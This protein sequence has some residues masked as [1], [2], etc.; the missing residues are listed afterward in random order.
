MTF[1]PAI[2][3]NRIKAE[4]T[5]FIVY[6]DLDWLGVVF[7]GDTLY[8]Y[9]G[10]V[11][12]KRKLLG[13]MTDNLNG[14]LPAPFLSSAADGSITFVFRKN[15]AGWITGYPNIG[16]EADITCHDPGVGGIDIRNTTEGKVYAV[17]NELHVSDYPIG[18]SVV[19]YNIMG[20]RIATHR[21]TSDTFLRTLS[22]GIYLV[23]VQ[24]EGK[25]SLF[26]MLIE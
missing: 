24:S 4:F 19:I 25:L 22:A 2:P 14:R 9:D 20:Q 10:N 8:V 12:D 6:S 11:V 15:S 16:W 7:P 18:A 3:G 26:K 13:S 5:R 17:K 1:Y 21:V 23:Q